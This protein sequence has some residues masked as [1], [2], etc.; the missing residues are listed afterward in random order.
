MAQLNAIQVARYI[1]NSY[2]EE[3]GVY[4]MDKE[5]RVWLQ[6]VL[7]HV[8][9]YALKVEERPLFAGDDF[10]MEARGPMLRSVHTEL[11]RPPPA[12][13]D[14]TLGHMYVDEIILFLSRFTAKQLTNA[15]LPWLE[16]HN[17]RLATI[18]Q[19]SIQK[20]WGQTEFEKSLIKN[21]QEGVEK[22]KLRHE[23]L[24]ARQNL[25]F[26]PNQIATISDNIKIKQDAQ[27]HPVVYL[28]QRNIDGFSNS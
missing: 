27:C 7:Y 26:D 8:Q 23:K 3:Q 4:Q 22:R 15:S 11:K 10:V 2:G 6:I 17:A 12:E 24:N 28:E 16:A 20:L 18:D 21:V 9:G 1:E 25:L 5:F 19:Q 13:E 14:Y